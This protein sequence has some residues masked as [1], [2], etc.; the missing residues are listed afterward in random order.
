VRAADLGPLQND[1]VPFAVGDQVFDSGLRG[2]ILEMAPK[3]ALNRD[4]SSRPIGFEQG[5]DGAG[6]V[7]IRSVAITQE[8]DSNDMTYPIRG[9]SS[10]TAGE[11]ER[12]PQRREGKDGLQLRDSHI[13]L[14]QRLLWMG[15]DILCGIVTEVACLDSINRA[16]TELRQSALVE[17]M[18]AR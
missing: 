18:T 9:L 5:L 13:R 15:T 11:S 7:V 4:P 3:N 8:Q 16:A 14:L 12:Q 6:N 2:D 10:D 1:V 17:A